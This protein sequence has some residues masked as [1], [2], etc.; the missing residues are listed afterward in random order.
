[1]LVTGVT[2]DEIDR[3]LDDSFVPVEAPLAEALV[4]HQPGGRLR[5]LVADGVQPRSLWDAYRRILTALQA[6][7]DV[8]P[9]SITAANLASS[10]IE[11]HSALFVPPPLPLPVMRHLAAQATPLPW[12]ALQAPFSRRILGIHLSLSVLSA[13]EPPEEK[14]DFVR[15]LVR[16]RLSERKVHLYDAP[17]YL[18]EP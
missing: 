3:V 13:P 17:V 8:T 15:E 6:S 12:G 9:L 18:F 10:V 1:M 11:A 14:T 16:L 5:A 4:L 7:C 2:A